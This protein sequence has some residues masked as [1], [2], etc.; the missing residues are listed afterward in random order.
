[1]RRRRRNHFICGDIPHGVPDK[2]G[3][4]EIIFILILTREYRYSQ[5]RCRRRCLLSFTL[6]T[7]LL[8]FRFS[9]PS[10]ILLFLERNSPFIYFPLSY[11]F[12]LIYFCFLVYSFQTFLKS[13]AMYI[14]DAQQDCDAIEK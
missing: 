2:S 1:M 4:T 11:Q 8:L 9:I 3:P 6:K 14:C 5:Y 10:S 13:T 12:S 7:C